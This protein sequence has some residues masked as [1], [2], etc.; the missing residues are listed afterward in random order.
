MIEG[1]GHHR[2]GGAGRVFREST[3]AASSPATAWR[4]PSATA[5][6][7]ATW[8]SCHTT[9]TCMPITGL[10]F[11]EACR[12][13]GGYLVN[14]DGYRYC[15]TTASAPCKQAE[16]QVHGTRPARPPEPGVLVLN[17]RRA[18]PSKHPVMARWSILD[19]RHLGEAL[20]ASV[21]R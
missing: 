16:E 12:G 14:K 18:A 10:L 11:T 19:L 20:C 2:T 4:W 8:S 21:C 3:L 17:S 7:C 13:E 6:R 5:S 9:P 15:R 1:V